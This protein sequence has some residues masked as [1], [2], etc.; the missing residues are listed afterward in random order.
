VNIYHNVAVKLSPIIDY[1]SITGDFSF[2]FVS[3]NG[4][5]KECLMKSGRLKSK[6]KA[7]LIQNGET[8]YFCERNHLQT[9]ITDIQKYIYEPDPAIIRAHLVNDLAV[10]LN[11]TR[12]DENI[13]LLT[14]A[15]QID[16]KFCKTYQV[17]DVFKY[18]LKTLNNYLSS[19]DIGIVDIKTRGFSEP[20]EHFRKKLKLSGKQKA[21]FFI[22]RIG[23]SHICIVVND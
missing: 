13:A 12:I 1:E 19:N 4:E 18:N 14:S 23:D 22:V 2:D 3:I 15:E 6:K 11:V 17:S 16:S 20:V 8:V 5:L 7:V 9:D 21:I 10:E